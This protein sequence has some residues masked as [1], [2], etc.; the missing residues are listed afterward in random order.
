MQ[1]E[2]TGT[3]EEYQIRL[4]GF[5][6]PLLR[7]A[8][9]ELRCEAL[10]RQTVIHGRLSTHQLGQLFERMEKLGVT[11][12]GLDCVGVRGGPEGN[13]EHRTSSDPTGSG[14]RCRFTPDG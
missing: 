13:R 9:K 1:P 6:G 11:L 3:T 2:T 8:F 7:A 4:L 14:E 12:V 5:L 10:P